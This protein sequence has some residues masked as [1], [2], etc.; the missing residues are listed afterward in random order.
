MTK[1]F[2]IFW[3]TESII[4]LLWVEAYFYLA[5]ARVLKLLPFSKISPSLGTYMEETSHSPNDTDRKIL[6]KVSNAV[7]MMSKYT[8]WESQCL[9]KAISAMKMLKRRNIES[10][11]YLGMGKDDN[12]KLAAHAWL[13]SGPYFITGSQG[14]EKFTVVGMFAGFLSNLSNEGEKCANKAKRFPIIK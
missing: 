6:S 2:K 10:T 5:F 3:N 9:V 1:K 14:K 8:F 11:L 7:E 13:R 4:K 12:G